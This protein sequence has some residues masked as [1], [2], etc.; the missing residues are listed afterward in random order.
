MISRW[1]DGVTWAIVIG[2]ACVYI[3]KKLGWI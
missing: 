2:I 1:D 3:L